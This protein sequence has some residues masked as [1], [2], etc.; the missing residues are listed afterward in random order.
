MWPLISPFSK[1]LCPPLLWQLRSRSQHRQTSTN[2]IKPLSPSPTTDTDV[3]SAKQMCLGYSTFWSEVI[4][5][6]TPHTSSTDAFKVW[7]LHYPQC[8]T[9]TP[10]SVWGSGVSS[11]QWMWLIRVLTAP[12]KGVDPPVTHSQ[13]FRVHSLSH[14][15][16]CLGVFKL[17]ENFSLFVLFTLLL[18]YVPP[19]GPVMYWWSVQ[20]LSPA[21]TL[22]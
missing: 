12:P 13:K 8:N 15:K 2:R 14:R 3:R 11:W 22:R 18:H 19:V 20:G 6:I 21:F 4:Q 17:T 1:F 10:C 7:L 5:M 16:I 9:S